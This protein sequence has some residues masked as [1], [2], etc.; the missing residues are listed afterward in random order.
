MFI[1]FYIYFLAFLNNLSIY[2]GMEECDNQAFSKY[3]D[4]EIQLP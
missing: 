2:D 4:A 1:Y 3:M